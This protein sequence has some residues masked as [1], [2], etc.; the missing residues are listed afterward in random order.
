MKKYINMNI[1]IYMTLVILMEKYIT[2]DNILFHQY[3]WMYNL[4]IYKYI[5]ID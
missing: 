5:Y 3:L 1:Y 2:K 4:D